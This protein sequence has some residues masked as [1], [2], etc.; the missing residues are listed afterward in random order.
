M[1]TSSNIFYICNSIYCSLQWNKLYSR[2]IFVPLDHI[3]LCLTSLHVYVFLTEKGRGKTFSYTEESST[4]KATPSAVEDTAEKYTEQQ[5]AEEQDDDEE[6][7]EADEDMNE[8]DINEME[9]EML[10][11]LNPMDDLNE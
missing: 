9:I 2:N 1:G 11:L 10:D 6:D 4:S 7:D 5:S 8:E 3:S